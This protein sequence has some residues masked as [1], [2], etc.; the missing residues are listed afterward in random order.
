MAW[1]G[2]MMKRSEGRESRGGRRWPH[3]I[4]ADFFAAAVCGLSVS[5][6][7]GAAGQEDTED[8]LGRVP[9]RAAQSD[10]SAK[11]GSKSG[12]LSGRRAGEAAAAATR[13]PPRATGAGRA[14]WRWWFQKQS[15]SRGE[16]GGR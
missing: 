8:V 12:G 4:G 3:G 10:G 7:T 9:A 15:S 13:R 1:L 14:R 6:L 5:V 2:Q 16:Q 11:A